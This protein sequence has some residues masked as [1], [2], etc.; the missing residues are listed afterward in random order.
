[1]SMSQHLCTKK[2]CLSRGCSDQS[3][4]QTV[5]ELSRCTVGLL[6]NTA[7]HI[8]IRIAI[9]HP[10]LTYIWIGHII[11]LIVWPEMYKTV[12]TESLQTISVLSNYC[13]QR[14][15]SAPGM[16]LEQ[17]RLIRPAVTAEMRSKLLLLVPEVFLLR[18]CFLVVA[19]NTHPKITSE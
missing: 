3:G 4:T 8:Y 17:D 10:H 19:K 6:C 1:M 9:T 7:A 14:D 15:W 16:A 12:M 5:K 11:H 13:K 2:T 18:W